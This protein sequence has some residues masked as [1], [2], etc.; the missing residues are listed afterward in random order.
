MA[1]GDQVL[2]WIQVEQLRI[3]LVR[4]HHRLLGYGDRLVLLPHVLCGDVQLCQRG[5]QDF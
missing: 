2:V 5:L 4:P 3:L 1:I